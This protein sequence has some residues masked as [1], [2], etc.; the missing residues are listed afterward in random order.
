MISIFRI[1]PPD[2]R[3]P[4]PLQVVF[5]VQSLFRLLGL[6]RDFHFCSSSLW[7]VRLLSR[8]R[9]LSKVFPSVQQFRCSAALC[10]DVAPRPPLCVI[11][12]FPVSG[13][14]GCCPISGPF[15]KCFLLLSGR[16]GFAFVLSLKAHSAA[17]DSSRRFPNPLA[18]KAAPAMPPAATPRASQHSTGNKT[19]PNNSANTSSPPR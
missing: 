5:L 13:A 10:E 16:M 2:V 4:V 6:S 12:W 15:P 11:R 9:L 8:L 14:S 3:S 17:I 18:C 1:M 19:R 7:C